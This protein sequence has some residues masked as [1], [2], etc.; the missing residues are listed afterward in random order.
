MKARV[1]L[2]FCLCLA[3]VAIAGNTA[4]AGSRR[5]TGLASQF[6]SNPDNWDPAGAPPEGDLLIFDVLL[7]RSMINDL[8]GLAVEGLLFDFQ[9]FVLAGNTITVGFG[10][11]GLRIVEAQGFDSPVK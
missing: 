11:G 2:L 5:W 1:C 3:S 9:D 10:N 4:Q 7:N 6:W 8:P